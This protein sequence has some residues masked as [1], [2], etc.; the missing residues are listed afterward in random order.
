MLGDA[1]HHILTTVIQPFYHDITC[2]KYSTVHSYFLQRQARFKIRNL[3][4]F[5]GLMVTVSKTERILD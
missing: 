1:E 2:C 5:H 4:P 3:L